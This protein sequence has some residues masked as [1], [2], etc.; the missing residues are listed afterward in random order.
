VT[1]AVNPTNDEFLFHFPRFVI[2][3]VAQE[4][5][6]VMSI[7]R[8]EADLATLESKAA[9]LRADLA[10]VE[11]RAEKIRAYIEISKVYEHGGT[12]GD[13]AVPR[14]TARSQH[15]AREFG[16]NFGKAIA[17]VEDIIIGEGHPVHTRVLIDRL[18]EMGIEIGGKEPVGNLS[19]ALSRS[20]KFTNNRTDGWSLRGESATI[21]AQADYDAIA[22][23]FI[24]SLTPAEIAIVGEYLKADRGVPNAIDGRLLASSRNRNNGNDL[25]TAQSKAL[26]MAFVSQ[27]RESS[28]PAG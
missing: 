23:E 8:A 22:S 11:A 19:S 24:S 15:V 28:P 4:L 26:R 17:A 6:G 13:N 1:R 5:E 2:T 10:E 27:V 25:T 14:Q 18:R 3:F 7:N 16:G 12:I 21:L 20:G 9:H